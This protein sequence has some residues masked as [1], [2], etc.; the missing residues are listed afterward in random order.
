[1]VAMG[2]FPLLMA[3]FGNMTSRRMRVIRQAFR[4]NNASKVDVLRLLRAPFLKLSLGIRIAAFL[5]VFILVSL[6]PGTLLS[7]GLIGIGAAV[8]AISSS[9]RWRSYD[10]LRQNADG[11]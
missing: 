7:I 2:S 5:G 1:M 9:V 6:K 10:Q 8:L 4:S 11:M 3:P